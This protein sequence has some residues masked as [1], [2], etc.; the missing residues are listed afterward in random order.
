MSFL[1]KKKDPPSA[2]A[3]PTQHKAEDRDKFPPPQLH[4]AHAGHTSTSGSHDSL[5]SSNAQSLLQQPGHLQ[6]SPLAQQLSD[7]SSNAQDSAPMSVSPMSTSPLSSPVAESRS[8]ALNAL[9]DREMQPAPSSP[10]PPSQLSPVPLFSPHPPSSTS[11]LVTPTSADAKVA[12]TATPSI[13]IPSASSSSAFP[14][15]PAPGSPAPQSGEASGSSPGDAA[16]FPVQEEK[17]SEEAIIL[18]AHFSSLPS[19]SRSLFTIGDTLGTGTFGRVRLVSYH[20][21]PLS[22]KPLH[23]ALKMLKKSEILRLKQVEHI[24]AEKAI[25]SRIC[26]PFIVNLFTAFQDERYLYMLMEYVIGGELFSQLRKV[27]RFSNDTARFY[28][29]EIVLALQYLHLK[30]IVYR[31]LKPENLLIDR[32]GH[33][34]I[35]DFGFAKI[36]EDRT[37]TLCGTPEYLGPQH[38]THTARSATLHAYSAQRHPSCRLSWSAAVSLCARV[39]LR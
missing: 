15:F 26:H 33:I 38:C 7:P 25:L 39:S 5:L 27:G 32:E 35:T 37:W 17:M 10:K 14:S 28:A 21:P 2:P 29:A 36:V 31:D 9:N 3:S 30:D 24:K 23:F 13:A 19:M 18:R 34:K 11:P 20:H 8:A 22:A 1:F 6:H 16:P 4:T 12:S